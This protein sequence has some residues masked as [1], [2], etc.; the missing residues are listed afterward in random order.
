MDLGFHTRNIGVIVIT[1]REFVTTHSKFCCRPYVV[2]V[3]SRDAKKGWCGGQV[4]DSRM[5]KSDHVRER[6]G[7]ME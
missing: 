3:V 5:R 6:E 4:I 7:T 2:V 1:T